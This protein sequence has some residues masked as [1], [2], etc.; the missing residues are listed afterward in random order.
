[1]PLIPH[2][3]SSSLFYLPRV[4][5][6]PT[7]F[8]TTI[9][10]IG[11]MLVTYLNTIAH[12]FLPVLPTPSAF[13]WWR[14][15]FARSGLRLGLS[16][17]PVSDVV[18]TYPCPLTPVAPGT[19]G[20]LIFLHSDEGLCYKWQN[21]VQLDSSEQISGLIRHGVNLPGHELLGHIPWSSSFLLDPL[22]VRER[23]GPFF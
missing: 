20:N 12:V 3:L 13:A 4:S 5:W 11:G 10:P 6:S 7:S 21:E 1:M 8:L 18:F 2:S 22:Y 9:L 17:S 14:F 16:K 15:L 19:W 23:E